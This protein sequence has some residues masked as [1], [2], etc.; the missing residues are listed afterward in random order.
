MAFGLCDLGLG[1]PELGYVRLSEIEEV[2]GILGL[3][4]ERDAQFVADR[5]LSAYANEARSAGAIR[6]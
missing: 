4:V 2:C 1:C 5:P 3:T 6:A